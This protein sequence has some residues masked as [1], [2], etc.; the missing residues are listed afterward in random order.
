MGHNHDHDDDH[1]HYYDDSY[2]HDNQFIFLR[3]YI[4]M[5]L[6]CEQGLDYITKRIREEMTIEIPVLGDCTDALIAIDDANFLAANL[7]KKIDHPTYE[8]IYTFKE[9]IPIFE[10]IKRAS[11]TENVDELAALLTNTL[12]PQFVQWTRQVQTALLKHIQQ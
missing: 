12:Q 10:Q 3:H 2:L 5:L 9:F 4:E 7:M 8:L 6:T 11:D 1:D